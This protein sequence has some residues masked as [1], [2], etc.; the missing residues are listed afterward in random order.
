MTF[1]H[2]SLTV[3]RSRS[4]RRASKRATRKAGDRKRKTA[5]RRNDKRR[6]QRGGSVAK[7]TKH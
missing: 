7:P 6:T 4:N 3:R 5:T 1:I 2:F